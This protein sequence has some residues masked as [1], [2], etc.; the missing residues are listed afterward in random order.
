MCQLERSLTSFGMTSRYCC[1]ILRGAAANIQWVWRSGKRQLAARARHDCVVRFAAH[2]NN[3]KGIDVD[4]PLGQL[5]VVTGPS[6]SVNQAWRSKQSTLKDSGATSRRSRHMRQFLDRMDK[7]P[8]MI[9]ADSACDCHRTIEPGQDVPS[10]VGTM[11]EIN[12]YL[13]LLARV[14]AH[15]SSCSRRSDPKLRNPSPSRFSRNFTVSSERSEA[16]RNEVENGATGSRELTGAKAE[17]T[18]RIKSLNLH[19]AGAY[20][21]I[22]R[23]RFAPLGMTNKERRRPFSSP[24]GSPSRQKPSRGNFSTFSSSKDTCAFGST[25]KSCVWMPTPKSSGS[26]DVYRSSRIASRLPKRIVPD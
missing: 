12:D 13:K 15:S 4:L 5:T 1:A 14:A 6:G 11:T 16:K 9:S 24:F 10:T 26:V 18:K 20:P 25:T 3:L 19:P 17:R 21:E 2:Q 22:P 23:L 7:P 8:W